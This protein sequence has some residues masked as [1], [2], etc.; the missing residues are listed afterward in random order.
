MKVTA[1][2]SEIQAKHMLPGKIGDARPVIV[3]LIN[4]DV[5]YMITKLGRPF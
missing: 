1:D 5:K 4:Y 2:P 3:K